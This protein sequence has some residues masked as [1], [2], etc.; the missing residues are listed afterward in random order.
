MRRLSFFLAIAAIALFAQPPVGD[1]PG[2]IAPYLPTP[3]IVVDEM[4]KAAQLK[5][6]E[7]L[8]DLGA[9][10][11]RIVIAAASKYKANA[12]GIELDD[13]LAASSADRI[14]ESGLQ[15]TARIIHGDLLKQDYSSADVVTVY[16]WPEANVKVSQLLDLQLKKGARV[17]AHDFEMGPW[18][19]AKTITVPDDGTGRSHTIFLYIR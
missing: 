19:P 2:S 6:G 15:K 3:N 14:A 16:L 18:K 5:P 1:A 8:F 4:L 13:A 17:V 10:D 12:I 11:G 9:G 7:T